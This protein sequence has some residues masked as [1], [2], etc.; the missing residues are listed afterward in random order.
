ML[1]HLAQWLANEVAD[2]L[3]EPEELKKWVLK[4]RRRLHVWCTHFFPKHDVCMHAGGRTCSAGIR[5]APK[6]RSRATTATAAFSPSSSSRGQGLAGE[7][8]G[9]IHSIRILVS[10]QLKGSLLV[11]RICRQFD[12]SQKD[13]PALRKSLKSEVLDS[14]TKV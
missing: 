13:I 7:S 2:K 6:C 1:G 4:D 12:F 9:G 14:L 3:K 10:R 11:A 5:C 8:R